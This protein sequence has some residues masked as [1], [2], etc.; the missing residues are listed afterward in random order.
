MDSVV[1]EVE[2]DIGLDLD[3]AAH[4]EGNVLFE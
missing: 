4:G 2:P 1:V 3:F